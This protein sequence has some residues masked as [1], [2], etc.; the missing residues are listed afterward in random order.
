MSQSKR[1]TTSSQKVSTVQI[2]KIKISVP[3]LFNDERDKLNSFLLQVKL[4][5]RRYRNEF[6]EIKNQIFFAFIY[7]KEDAFKWF[8]HF[9][10][11]Y[12]FKEEEA[13]EPEIRFIFGISEAFEKRIRRIFEDINQERTAEKQLYDLRQKKSTVNYLI[14]FQHITTN[15]KWDNA[16]FISQFYQKLREKIKNEI[17]KID[18]SNDLQKMIIKTVFINNQQYERRL[19]KSKYHSVILNKKFKEKNYR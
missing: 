13:R 6:R 7:L 8:K 16:A 12:F 19:E 9:L 10:I 11:D 3:D 4:Y 17:V 15:T 18:R 2:N 5:T 14:S 1:S